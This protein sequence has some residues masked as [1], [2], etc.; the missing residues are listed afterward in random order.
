MILERSCLPS[1]IDIKNGS[2]DNTL[3]MR[4]MRIYIFFTLIEFSR[5]EEVILRR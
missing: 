1:S 2:K 5:Y 4:I 3:L